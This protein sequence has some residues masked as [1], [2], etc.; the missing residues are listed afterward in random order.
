MCLM[1]TSSACTASIGICWL[2][3]SRASSRAYRLTW[4]TNLIATRKTRSRPSP[5]NVTSSSTC[6]NHQHHTHTHTHTQPFYGS[7]EIVRDNPGEPVPEETFTHYTHRGHQSSLSAFSIYYDT[8]H[9]LYSIH[10]LY[11]LFP[12]SL[13]KF[14]LVYLLACYLS[15]SHLC[16]LK[17]LLIFLS[18]GPGL[19]SMQHTTLYT[20]AVQSP[21]HFQWY[22]LIGIAAMQLIIIA[23]PIIRPLFQDNLGKPAPERQNHSGF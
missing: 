5:G 16:L 8:W 23:T 4:A 9:P 22:I 20:T 15:N 12:Q 1:T 18:Y 19:T 3:P 21:S 7:V 2:R 11:S 6:E 14:S 17:C 13:S 10:V